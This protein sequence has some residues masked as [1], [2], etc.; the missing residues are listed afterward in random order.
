[1]K[2][3]KNVYIVKCFFVILTAFYTLNACS[4]NSASLKDGYYTAETAEF[5]E[6]GWK[7]YLSVFIS[8]GRIILAEYNAYNSSGFIKSWDM[9]YMRAM[10]AKDGTYPSAYSR[11]YASRFLELQDTKGIDA[12]S[13]AT[14]SYNNFIRLADA[15]MKNAREGN[16]KT[17][18][19]GSG[20]IK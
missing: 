12:I 1:M 11:H 17:E 2:S 10:N 13:G 3:K 5:D 18:R 20:E 4:P 15:V 16:G 19:V 8:E 9:D 6:H 14:A 7:E